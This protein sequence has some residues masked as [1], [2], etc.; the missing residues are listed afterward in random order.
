MISDV[1]KLPYI[2]WKNVFYESRV[3]SASTTEC[4]TERLETTLIN[5]D[6]KCIYHYNKTINSR[7]GLTLASDAGSGGLNSLGGLG[8]GSSR[9]LLLE[10]KFNNV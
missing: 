9:L 4:V 3:G 8:L 1:S 10:L 7:Y 2:P 5:S 6:N